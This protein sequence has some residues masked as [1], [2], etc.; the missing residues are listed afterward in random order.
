MKWT[1]AA[2]AAAGLALAACT[3]VVPVQT[4]VQQG[5]SDRTGA[6]RTGADRTGADRSRMTRAEIEAAATEQKRAIAEL[7]DQGVI[8]YEEAARRQYEVQRTTYALTAGEVAYWNA[9]FQIAALVDSGQIDRAEY[10]RRIQLAYAQY[11]G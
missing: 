5:T 11:V 8:G 10:Q 4:P 7:R 6:D 2:A 9:A 1:F 3:T